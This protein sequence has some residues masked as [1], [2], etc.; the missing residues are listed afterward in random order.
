[1]EKN[2]Q[3]LNCTCPICG[4]KFH[5]KPYRIKR[6]KN[7]YC[8]Q[9]CH[10]K[11][12]EEY[13][14]GEKNHQYGLKGR[15]NASWK[16]DRRVSKYGY[17]QIRCLDHPF[18]G[19]D[20]FMFEHR[21]VAEKYLLTDENSIEVDGKRY[22]RP[23]YVVHH[24]NENKKDNRVENLAVMTKSEHQRLHSIKKPQLR[25]KITGRFIKAGL[26]A[27]KV[28]LDKN[29]YM[30][31][32]AHL[33]DGGADLRTPKRFTIPPKDMAVIDT[34]VHVEIPKGYAGFIKSKSGL[35]VNDGIIVD[36]LID[37]GF[38]GSIHVCMFNLSRAYKVFETGDKIAQ[39]VIKEVGL[40]DFIQVV[41]IAGG[42]RGAD[43]FGST[44]R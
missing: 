28:Q 1:M 19:K 22:L 43:G 16:R 17:I 6:S 8:S 41:K 38:D 18:R 37:A 40:P 13:C 36:G 9:K 26:R 31:V 23:D 5:L 29:A 15:K 39:L 33:Q 34:G 14:K 11:A 24:I 44:G 25:D 30:P 35:M 3:Y 7:N 4:L 27:I 20:D 2:E 10:N 42:E 21:L 12:K 32:R